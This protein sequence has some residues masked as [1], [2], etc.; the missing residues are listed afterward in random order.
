[1][2]RVR[3]RNEDVF[4]IR[5]EFGFLAVADGMG[6]T[7]AGHVAA[8][9]AIDEVSSTLSGINAGRTLQPEDLIEAVISA[10]AK[11]YEHGQT[12]SDFAGMGTTIVY[13]IVYGSLATF[14]HVGDSRGFLYRKRDLQQIT[15]DHSLVQEKVDR[16]EMTKEE[17]QV[18]PMRNL[19]TRSIGP[20]PTVEP[21]ITTAELQPGDCI[22]LCSDGI[23][24]F[25]PHAEIEEVMDAHSHNLRFLASMLV[26]S[27]DKHGSTDNITTVVAKV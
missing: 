7:S 19:V 20:Q 4:S 9:I 3:S 17:A 1:M 13:C 2:G 5:E 16:G 22:M 21:E 8:R 14:C 25:V 18:A 27:A 6:G 15:K 10:N 26:E 12:Y 11:V 24:D 23:S